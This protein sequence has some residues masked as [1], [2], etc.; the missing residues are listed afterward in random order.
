LPSPNTEFTNVWDM[1]WLNADHG[2]VGCRFTIFETADGGSTWSPALSEPCWRMAW[3]GDERGCIVWFGSNVLQVTLDGGASWTAIE[4]PVSSYLLDA[5]WAAEDKIWIA[6]FGSRIVELTLLAPSDVPSMAV[7]T[8]EMLRVF[9]HPV[10]HRLRVDFSSA[11]AGDA[12]VAWFDAAGR[13]VMEQNVGILEGLNSLDWT[14]PEAA[15]SVLF[16]RVALPDGRVL[17]RKVISVR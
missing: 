2:F 15:G 12:G 1:H 5:S 4:V 3:D 17:S 13:S 9:P 8:T 7:I 14:V 16:L 6:S 11:R 10:E